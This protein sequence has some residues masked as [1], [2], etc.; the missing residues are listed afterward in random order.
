MPATRTV[1]LGA[2]GAGKSTFITKLAHDAAAGSIDGAKQRV[3]MLLILRDFVDGFRSGEHTL[4]GYLRLACR[5]PYNIDISAEAMDYLLGN[6]RA[7]V[8]LDGLDE[9]VDPELRTR[10]NRLV[11]GFVHQHPLVPMVATSRIVGYDAVALDPAL[12]ETVV[13]GD[14]TD[15]QVSQYARRWFVLDEATSTAEQGRL[16]EAFLRESVAAAELRR[17]P[18][19]LSLLCA[20]YSYE[21]YIP[22]NLA[23]IYE[24]CATMLFDQW[25][26]MRGIAMPVQFQG[27][28]R[29]AIQ[30][31]AWHFLDGDRG[32]QPKHRVEEVLARYLENQ[33]LPADDAA[34]TAKSF[35]E[36]CTGRAWV[37]AD[38]GTDREEPTYGFTHRT[39]LEYFAAE[40]LV[41]TRRTGTALAEVLRPKLEQGTW[42]V[43]A[44]IALQLFDR[45]VDNGAD[46]LLSALLADLPEQ[47]ERCSAVLGACSQSLAH[48]T[49]SPAMVARIVEADLNL[50]LRLSLED[51]TPYWASEQMHQDVRRFDQPLY[52][53][54]YSTSEDNL[55]YVQAALSSKLIEAVRNGTCPVAGYLAGNLG[56]KRLEEDATRSG[57][58]TVVQ[59]QLRGELGALADPLNATTALTPFPASRHYVMDGCLVGVTIP[60][61]LWNLQPDPKTGK[62]PWDRARELRNELLEYPTPW[63][64]GS[65][66]WRDLADLDAVAWSAVFGRDVAWPGHPE[67]QATYAVLMAPYLETIAFGRKIAGAVRDDDS[68][69]AHDRRNGTELVDLRGWPA[70]V[71]AFAHAWR[72]RELSVIGN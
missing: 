2:P 49:P 35:L 1:I 43:V 11:E 33:G 45:Q 7:V 72:R 22:R 25:D 53:A 36:F 17:S 31:L 34:A 13:L 66:W 61:P 57:I 70:K 15:E 28:L 12:F 58:W 37:L 52:T 8:L 3:P 30:H 44:Q 59:D 18:L 9:L 47:T 41:R 50:A 69:L 20:M 40:H 32:P 60:G 16:T 54:M 4:A 27:R 24:R 21:R 23:R 19:L 56:R 10:V 5:A 55:P 48:A 62:V 46:E 26:A 51:R 6:G 39:F 29:Y 42:D 14:F 63:I 68:G 65:R 71:A 64:A 38:L 67:Q